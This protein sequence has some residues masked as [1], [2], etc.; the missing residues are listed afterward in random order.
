[1]TKYTLYY[2][3]Q[4]NLC[5]REIGLLKRLSSKNT[6][7]KDIHKIENFTDLPTKEHMLKRLHLGT[8][9]GE[10]FLGL[11]ATIKIWRQTKY[12]F[13]VRILTIPGIR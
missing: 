3:G 13:M 4:C 12:S 6:D 5:A 11:N 7:F 9:H 10:W 8:N 2:D 1:M